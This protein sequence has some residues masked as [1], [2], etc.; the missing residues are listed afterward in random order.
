MQR[1]IGHADE[2]GRSLLHAAAASGSA[3]LVGLCRHQVL[4]EVHLACNAA[5]PCI[6]LHRA[7][8]DAFSIN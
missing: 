8:L 4:K 5:T 1:L 6:A 3:P 2:D 7:M